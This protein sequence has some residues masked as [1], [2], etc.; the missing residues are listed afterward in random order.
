MKLLL[1]TLTALLTATDPVQ[2]GRGADDLYREMLPI[3]RSIEMTAEQNRLYQQ[4]LENIRNLPN[5]TSAT[6]PQLRE[7]ID[8]ALEKSTATVDELQKEVLSPYYGVL[9]KTIQAH[10]DLALSWA[11]F[12]NSLNLEQ[13]KV[14]RTRIGDMIQQKFKD[15]TAGTE[16]STRTENF[17]TDEYARKFSYTD[18]QRQRI[19]ELMKKRDSIMA[20]AQLRRDALPLRISRTLL[21]PQIPFTEFA[22]AMAESFRIGRETMTALLAVSSECNQV[23]DNRQQKMMADFYRGKLKTLRFMLG[24]K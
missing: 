6:K 18:D 7:I 9:E 16:R 13:R 14:F 23:L 17:D 3:Q 15:M 1:L 11:Q 8:S 10:Y 5:T 12:D 19:R 20:T 22:D 2:A 21:D 4:A 24:N